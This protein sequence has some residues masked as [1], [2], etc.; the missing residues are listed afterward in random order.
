MKRPVVEIPGMWLA[1]M[2]LGG[3]DPAKAVQHWVTQ[4]VLAR[5]FKR[6]RSL[7]RAKH[8]AA[9]LKGWRKRRRAA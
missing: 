5:R 6:Q 4:G 2:S 8:R 9:A 7:R 1:G 3:V